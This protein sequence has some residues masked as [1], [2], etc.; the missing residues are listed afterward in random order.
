MSM[1]LQI[2]FWRDIIRK[3]ILNAKAF[4]YLSTYQVD[5]FKENDKCLND[6]V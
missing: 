3:S 2:T 1:Q 6:E 4:L 5:V